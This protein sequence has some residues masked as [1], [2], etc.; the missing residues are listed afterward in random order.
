M[1]PAVMELVG[2]IGGLVEAADT[3]VLP[4][5]RLNAGPGVDVAHTRARSPVVG[6]VLVG[7]PASRSPAPVHTAAP[8]APATVG[9]PSRSL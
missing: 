8:A 9:H 1:H 7:L 3:V 4:V 5:A 6:V 2:G